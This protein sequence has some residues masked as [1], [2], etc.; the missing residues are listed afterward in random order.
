MRGR[1][2][3]AGL[4]ALAA[5]LTGAAP[6]SARA[7]D[8]PSEAKLEE[9]KELFRRGVALIEAEA[10]E[11]AL[12]L[13]LRSRALVPGKGN[14]SNAAVC[15]EKLGRYDE[16][17][18]MAEE[19]VA[20]FS[21]SLDER[22]R[23]E[24]GPRMA[25]LRKKVASLVV[26]SDVDATLIVDGR[27]RG[28]VPLAAPVRLLAGKHLV[29][30]VKPGFAPQEQTILAVPGVLVSITARL[31]MIP[32]AGV[33][34]VEDP[35]IEGANVIVDE[36]RVG[37]VPWEGTL[38]AG[39]HVVR[40]EGGARGSAPTEILVVEGQTSLA[41]PASRELGEVLTLSTDPLTA[42]IA[43]DGVVIAHGRWIGRLPKGAHEVTVAEPGYRT[44]HAT[45]NDGLSPPR[46][47][48]LIRVNPDDP[49]WPR[50]SRGR[51]VAS[52]FASLA[53]AGSF[54]GDAKVSDDGTYLGAMGGARLGFRFPIGIAPEIAVGYLSARGSFQRAFE[55]SFKVRRRTESVVYDLNDEP[56]FRGPFAMAGASFTHPLG[57]LHFS[58]RVG[59]GGILVR[60]SDPI[61]GTITEAGVAPPTAQCEA[62]ASADA[63]SPISV[64]HAT[65]VLGT[66]ALF[67]VTELGV[68]YPFKSFDL[69]VAFG[70]M[71][72]PAPGPRYRSR[73]IA[74]FP[75]C[76]DHNHPQA[77][78]CAPVSSAV[79]DETSY[80]PFALWL[81]EVFAAFPF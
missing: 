57:P 25:E 21:D 41:R 28:K 30:V 54:N 78:A 16:A 76:P 32:G 69:G 13:F 27:V 22:D 20:K 68:A 80:G 18:E 72:F 75:G 40:T 50:R 24:I 52:A 74:V 42:A 19:V 26:A 47:H 33:L 46:R 9:A 15:L 70:G 6:R 59:V 3:V 81:P 56:W 12:A 71:F 62:G 1:V 31:Q 66:T 65:E 67:V 4:L 34:R 49:R 60:T 35:S 8:P 11:P 14:T 2:L 38:R 37:T 64:K 79:A 77:L 58:S 17:L 48:F 73:K 23:K 36:A 7:D 63:C 53:V 5:T 55:S 61:T 44:R 51:F 10:Y 43:I 29:R 39:P 45:V